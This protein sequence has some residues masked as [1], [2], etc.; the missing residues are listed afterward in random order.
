MK[1]RNIWLSCCLLC[2]SAL[3]AFPQMKASERLTQAQVE[4]IEKSIDPA[5]IVDA[6]SFSIAEKCYVEYKPDGSSITWVE[7]WSQV[8]TEQGVKD[9]DAIPLF[10]REGDSDATFMEATIF[11]KDGSV[12]MIDLQK[13]ISIVTANRDNDSNI[14]DQASKKKILSLPPMNIGDK[15]HVVLAYRTIRPRIEN[16]FSDLNILESDEAPVIYSEYTVNAPK[17]LPIKSMKV[18]REIPGTVKSSSEV[19]PNGNTRYT[20]VARNV[21]QV[22]LEENM[23]E[24]YTQL[25]RVMLSTFES[26][27]E[28]STWYWDLCQNHMVV[29]PAIKDKVTE[30][31]KDCLTAKEKIEALHGFVA[32]EIRYMGIIAE[33]KAPGYAPHDIGM[34]FDNRYGV[35]RDKGA[36][37]VAM[38]RE[39]GINAFPVLINAG[40]K[41]AKDVPLAYFNHAIVGI[42]T[43]DREYTFVDPTDETSRAELPS[44]LNDCTYLVCR[45]EGETLRITDVAPPSENMATINTVANLDASGNL[46]ITADVLLTGI[47]DTMYRPL[48]VRNAPRRLQE[49]FDG[50]IKAAIPGATLEK[51][52]FTPADP[53]DITQPINLKFTINVPGYANT[54]AKGR[55]VLRLPFLSRTLGSVSILFGGIDTPTR[56]YDFEISST[57]GVK[58]TLTFNGIERLGKPY[59]L[60]EDPIIK[61]N[62]ASYSVTCKRENK[63]CFVFVREMELSKCVYTPEDYLTLRSFAKAL[64]RNESLKPFFIRE[65]EHEADVVIEKLSVAVKLFDDPTLS[66]TQAYSKKRV[67]TFKGK[68]D[69]AEE[70]FYYNP[71][72][73]T[74][75]L[76]TAEV[77]TATGDI[78]PISEKELNLLDAMGS[79][80]TP[81]YP[82]N[83]ELVVSLPAVDIG[84]ATIIDYTRSSKKLLP[85]SG[86]KTFGGA[87]P[88]END[89]FTLTLPLAKI[90]DIII[91]EL[92]MKYASIKKS[93]QTIDT[94]NDGTVDHISYTWTAEQIPSVAN[95]R[96]LPEAIHYLPS[97][98][99]AWKSAD[100]AVALPLIYKQI[101]ALMKDVRKSDL[102]ES[103]AESIEDSV[104]SDDEEALLRATIDL[105]AKKVRTVGPA[106]H[107][108]TTDTFSNPEVV[109]ND[110][111]GNRMDVL[112]LKYAILRELGI[113]CDIVFACVYSDIELNTKHSSNFLVKEMP[114]WSMWT[115][116]YIQ[117]EDGRCIGD[118]G[119][120]DL[121]GV[122]MLEDGMLYTRKGHKHFK[123]HEAL[124]NNVDSVRTYVINSDG[125]A[126]ITEQRILSG[127]VSG[128][129]RRTKRD[130]TPETYRRAALAEVEALAPSAKPNC[131]YF[132]GSNYP[133]ET[134]VSAEVASYANIQG[135]IMSIPVTD[136]IG[137]VY[138]LR[139]TKRINPIWQSATTEDTRVLEFWLPADVEIIS[140]P[141]PFEMELPGGGFIKLTRNVFTSDNGFT[142]ITFALSHRADPA[143]LENWQFSSLIEFDRN[144][145]APTMSTLN[146]RLSKQK[147]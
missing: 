25:Q 14:Y 117:L 136:F 140:G 102:I 125:D 78:L 97:V 81:R 132:I 63:D 6:H 129:M 93:T 10:F 73:E 137:P 95:E 87:Y 22:F 70:K 23:P 1:L 20:W 4:E 37:L 36:L 120:F 111:Y 139:G 110:G 59:M 75:N 18:I 5:L 52:T 141:E 103:I 112:L 46:A 64:T 113:D 42:D 147:K 27:E 8:L 62:G 7:F 33:D 51:M 115:N 9:W 104:D 134:R 13:N 66:E 121:P 61:A 135:D 90:N 32:Q 98:V 145:I 130:F 119:E 96:A 2:V 77:Q 17:D 68:R 89:S 39:A 29:T 3:W 48:L 79:E 41:L 43:G 144:L 71:T 76:R 45:P 56:K 99:Y 109:Y 19:L 123:Q 105:V 11:R 47:N 31:T 91:H 82:K 108:L 28:V 60:P 50:I 54:D 40:Q 35:C 124:A 84:A 15:I 30:L 138:G 55:T 101:D 44:Y 143:M 131:L 86:R 57:C 74:F 133:T 65:N 83:K 34:T 38:L 106:W 122:S 53:Q 26:W 142:R 88:V 92:N 12:E 85:V 49:I 24:K 67:L 69:I 146:I 16:T 72:F 126:I 127:V 128:L 107:S 114:R 21:P 94:D 58:E 80:L 100:E 116:P 118:E